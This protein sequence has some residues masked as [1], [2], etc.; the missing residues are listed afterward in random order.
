MRRLLLALV[1][2]T[3][4]VGIGVAPAAADGRVAAEGDFTVG[5]TGAPD[6][7]PLPGGRCLARIPVTLA[8]TGTLVGTAPGTIRIAFAA[9][10]EQALADRPGT[11]ADVFTFRGRFTGT[12][13]GEETRARLFY[14]GVTQPGGQ[15]R[16]VMALYG[17]SHGLLSVDATAGGGG[18]YSGAVR[19]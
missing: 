1:L 7:R 18:S 17:G 16:G 10:C 5:I 14:S 11:Y 15:V 6:T 9:P 3:A 4:L 13:A 8:F 12:V 2:C 19:P